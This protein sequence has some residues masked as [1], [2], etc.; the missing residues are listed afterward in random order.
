MANKFQT[1]CKQFK[2]TNGSDV[3]CNFQFQPGGKDKGWLLNVP[4]DSLDEFWINYYELK[5]KINQPSSLL[6]RP[7]SGYNPIKIDLDFKLK[8]SDDDLRASTIKHKYTL[9]QVERLIREYAKE[10]SEL[11][12]WPR[13][14][15]RFTIF[16]KST[17]RLRG[18]EKQ[19]QYL[20]DGIH[21]MSPEIVADNTI[22]LA[23]YKNLLKNTTAQELCAEFKS[24][25]TMDKV[26]DQ[27]V[28]CTNSWFPVGSG[29][30]E[31]DGD[32]YMPTASYLVKINSQV[33]GSA[34]AA[35]KSSRAKNNNIAKGSV[36]T[37]ARD[38]DYV[39]KMDKLTQIKYFANVG[40]K[41]TVTP[42]DSVNVEQLKDELAQDGILGRNRKLGKVEKANMRKAVPS[43]DRI[44]KPVNKEFIR[45]L[46]NCLS[47]KRVDDFNAW[48]N[49]GI[50]MY[51]ISP[52]LYELWDAWSSQSDKYDNDYC[53]RKWYTEFIKNGDKYN[54]GM[55]QLKQYA[56]EDNPK[57]YSM[58]MDTE[59]TKFLESLIDIFMN[60]T[61]KN[62]AGQIALVG[63][64]KEYIGLYC[65]WQVKCA[66][67]TNNIWYRFKAERHRW[68]SD[69]GAN[70][71]YKLLVHDI[72][73]QLINLNEKKGTEMERLNMDLNR[74]SL[75]SVKPDTPV[76]YSGDTTP[77]MSEA[78]P[79]GWDIQMHASN[80]IKQ[81]EAMADDIKRQKEVT[82]K[83]MMTIE[84][85]IKY[86][87][88][89]SNRSNIIKDL[90][91]ECFEPEFYETLDNNPNV[92]VCNNCVLDMSTCSLRNGL[93]SDMVTLSSRIDFPMDESCHEYQE[94]ITELEDFF[95]KLFPDDDLCEYVLNIFAE[96]LCG[97]RDRQEFFIHTGVGSNG[98]SML[99]K[100]IRI[101]FGDYFGAPDASLFNTTTSDPN[102]ASPALASLRGCRV[103]MG[104]E[105]PAD[106]DMQP[107]VIKRVTGGDP[108]TCRHL[109]KDLITYIP[110]NSWH[111]F[112]NDLPKM[113][114][115]DEG[116]LRRLRVL[117]YI[118]KFVDPNSLKLKT[119]KRYPNHYPKDSTLSKKMEE[120]PPYFLSMLWNRY[121]ILK[122]N[123]FKDL[124][125]NNRPAVVE[126]AIKIYMSEMNVISSFV[127]ENMEEFVGRRQTVREVY[128]AFKTFLT[129][130]GNGK[131][132][133]LQ[134]FVGQV[135]HFIGKPRKVKKVD[136]FIDWVVVGPD[137]PQGEESID[138]PTTSSA[139]STGRK[140]SKSKGES[141]RRDEA[142]L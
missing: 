84:K 26:V 30:P 123:G 105:P 27:R 114:N 115:T 15:A 56:Y 102:A 120:W 10:L 53:F 61:T 62:I 40:K 129:D 51:N 103:A 13:N 37:M 3:P 119:A 130:T 87:N 50:C 2:V 69:K 55:D 24:M 67:N 71:L 125:D 41:I 78:A 75:C 5:V 107:D 6:E 112:C 18:T 34:K 76:S 28:I 7:H 39:S 133:N 98:K 106:K 95:E 77:Q 92:F 4:E 17:P 117:P 31:D 14:G 9:D 116:I 22:L 88:M 11:M 45:Y 89:N 100:L 57:I 94:K 91:Q 127:K 85:V 135:S 136:H 54:L 101:T 113:A 23:A 140:T 131:R 96:S 86:I 47:K 74:V 12:E 81:N 124:D 132:V 64:L 19:E 73:K 134:Q 93:P 70:M 20:K 35:S 43:K 108:V 44:R 97:N 59:R 58:F 49:V 109:N 142:P 99:E 66:D 52:S 1:Y 63:K 122:K 21:I 111:M 128:T 60:D 33:T 90:S 16:E 25:D 82:F 137:G 138:I 118:S 65:D 36:I 38:D 110:T 126:E 139:V 32:Y 72:Y 83:K 79:T 8:P 80:Q 48:I 68:E 104:A 42:H 121:K 141:S 46:L 29:K